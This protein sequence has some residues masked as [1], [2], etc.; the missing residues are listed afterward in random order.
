[1]NVFWTRRGGDF[2]GQQQGE[3]TADAE[4]IARLR[5]EGL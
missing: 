4:R 2:P 3:Q 5:S 1:M